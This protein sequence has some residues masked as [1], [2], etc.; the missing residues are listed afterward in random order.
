MKQGG[1]GCHYAGQIRHPFWMSEQSF[2]NE[3]P[4]QKRRRARLLLFAQAAQISRQTG[5]VGQYQAQ[6]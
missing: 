3:T 6:S 1:I 5:Q 2:T 4:S